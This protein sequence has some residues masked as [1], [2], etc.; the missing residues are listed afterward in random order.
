LKLKRSAVSN[1]LFIAQNIEITTLFFYK[2]A[3]FKK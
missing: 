3:L 2:S 1:W